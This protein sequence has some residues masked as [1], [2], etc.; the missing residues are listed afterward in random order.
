MV[1]PSIIALGFEIPIF[2]IFDAD[3]NENHPG[4]RAMHERDNKAILGLFGGDVMN[5]FPSALTKGKNFLVWPEN[6]GNSVAADLR[7]ELGDTEF[8]A[9]KN[10]AR[11][12]FENEGSLDKASLYI[13]Q[14]LSIAHGRG[15]KCPSLNSLVDAVEAFAGN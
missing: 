9:V 5:P 15:A 7:L 4:K 1:R 8:E 11:T 3:G 12:T 13:G 6:I 14:L 2:A 10:E